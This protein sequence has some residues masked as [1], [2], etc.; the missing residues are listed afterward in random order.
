MVVSGKKCPV[1]ASV[2]EVAEATIRCF[3]RTVP[4]AVPGIVFLSGGQSPELA[5]AHLNAINKLGPQPWRLSFS[6][7]RAL[8]DP[9]LAAWVGDDA[10]RAAAQDALLDRTRANADASIGELAESLVA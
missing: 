6:F 4:A 5:S 8:V 7:G 10:N 9:A 3:R 1:Q 2:E